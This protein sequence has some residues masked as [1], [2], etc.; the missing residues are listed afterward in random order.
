MT[1]PRATVGTKAATAV[2]MEPYEIEIVINKQTGEIQSTV[3]GVIGPDCVGLTA[4]LDQI[5]ETIEHETT[6]DFDKKPEQVRVPGIVV[7]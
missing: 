1:P 2:K 4:W 3:T 7:G 6:G 5:G